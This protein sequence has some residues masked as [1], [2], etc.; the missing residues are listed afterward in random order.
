M[1]SQIII[2]ISTLGLGIAASLVTAPE[3]RAFAGGAG[4]FSCTNGGAYCKDHHVGFTGCRFANGKC[5]A[6]GEPCG[7]TFSW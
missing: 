3:A 5:K 7:F 6:A 1:K 2:L 4:C